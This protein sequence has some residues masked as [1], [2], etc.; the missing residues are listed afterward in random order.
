MQTTGYIKEGHWLQPILISA[1]QWPHRP[2]NAPT[3]FY[4]VSKKPSVKTDLAIYNHVL[5]ASGQ[6]MSVSIILGLNLGFDSCDSLVC[7]C[8]FSHIYITKTLAEYN[9]DKISYLDNCRRI[10]WQIVKYR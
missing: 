5:D 2:C 6:C 10:T 8:K 4:R 9:I 3:R 7:F 1:S